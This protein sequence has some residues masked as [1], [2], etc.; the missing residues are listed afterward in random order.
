M[1]DEEKAALWIT[2]HGIPPEVAA[3]FQMTEKSGWVDITREPKWDEWEK[4]P[5]ARGIG[6][7]QWLD[8]YTAIMKLD[9][10]LPGLVAPVVG[11]NPD[12]FITCTWHT[13]DGRQLD[14]EIHADLLRAEFRWSMIVDGAMQRHECRAKNIRPLFECM[15]ATF[16]D[17]E[18]ARSARKPA[19][20]NDVGSSVT[21]N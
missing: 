1:N 19:I 2:I 8:A 9:E 13:K 7:Q 20:E 14:L 17:T 18:R 16:G 21:V 5:R 11:A 10:S 6:K 15:K 12:G 3:K 4:G